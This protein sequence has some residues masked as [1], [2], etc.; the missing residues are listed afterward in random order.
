[1]ELITLCF[2]D[3]PDQK[4]KDE[5]QI[6]QINYFFSLICKTW[7]ALMELEPILFCYMLALWWTGDPSR[8]YMSLPMTART[9]FHTSPHTQTHLSSHF[10]ITFIGGLHRCAMLQQYIRKRPPHTG[11][12]TERT[13]TI[14]MT[15]GWSVKSLM[16]LID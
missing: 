5:D 1:M 14:I 3:V 6:Y 7:F 16:H 12:K 15:D 10:V 13:M 2:E 11:R 8:M 4:L 9:E